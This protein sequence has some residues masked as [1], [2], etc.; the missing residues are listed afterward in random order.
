[1]KKSILLL[2][3]I[4]GIVLL[5]FESNAQRYR[6]LGPRFL[7]HTPLSV[8]G[9]KDFRPSHDGTTSTSNWARPIDS[10][11]I[12]VPLVKAYDSLACSTLDN[13]TGGFPSL[14][15]SFALVY[16]GDCSFVNKAHYAQQAGALGV[17]IVNNVE[18]PALLNMSED[19]SSPFAGTIQIPVIMIKKT[20]GDMLN[21][22]IN[23]GQSVVVTLT[24][25]GFGELND[26]A[27][28]PNSS[29]VPH[30]MAVPYTQY[31]SDNNNPYFYG[32]YLS[33]IVANTGSSTEMNVNIGR[34]V[35][36]TPNSGTPS[37]LIEDT[38]NVA[39]FDPADSVFIFFSL[40]R[41]H[42]HVTGSGKLT[43]EYTVS[44]QSVELIDFDNHVSFDVAVTDSVFSKARYDVAKGQPIIDNSY[45]HASQP[46]ITWGPMYYIQ[47][48]GHIARLVQ[49]AVSADGDDDN[50]S[51]LQSHSDIDIILFKWNDYNGDFYPEA[52]EFDI[53]GIAT[54]QFNTSD[55][56]SKFFVVP[57]ADVNGNIGDNV[58]L[59]GES[60]YWVAVELPSTL[61]LGTDDQT[62]YYSRAMA[63]KRVS[64]DP[65]EVLEYYAPMNLGDRTIFDD[66]M[67]CRFPFIT[68]PAGSIQDIDSIG[69]RSA[70]GL[71]PAVALHTS[72]EAIKVGVNEVASSVN[73]T[74]ELYPIP[75]TTS[76]SVKIE[77]KELK[78]NTIEYKILDG[79][80][81][82]VSK[83]NVSLN[84][85]SFTIPT[86]QLATGNYFLI[87]KTETGHRFA[88]KFIVQQN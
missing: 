85:N 2:L 23:D 44:S 25:W 14:S 29:S 28:V 7:V 67:L 37:V 82:F 21:S 50:S 60:W 19:Q 16:R 30:A 12:Q 43:Y 86:A 33:T 36:F 38:I 41:K 74:L 65:F 35:S 88:R 56:G 70:D 81:R 8:N 15:G 76:L 6:V 87:L 5:S 24:N 63:S 51:I 20:D 3:L 42:A 17:V 69:F 13:G 47:K 73:E 34:R 40:D 72:K 39:S 62:S 71:I 80:G 84:G 11:W 83:N 78:G 4:S 22:L 27:I 53:V 68:F 46:I 18:D 48:G 52:G 55:S 9:L 1:M 10:A 64:A 57:V 61:F 58:V 26:L 66:D 31:E 59:D 49:L 75:A 77:S 54:K 32:D 79:Q 45:R